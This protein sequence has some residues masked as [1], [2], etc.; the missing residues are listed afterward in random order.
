LFNSGKYQKPVTLLGSFIFILIQAVKIAIVL[1][2]SWNIYNFRLGLVRS[3][4]NEGHEI[5]AVAPYDDYSSKLKEIGC[6]Y[7]KVMMDSRGANPIKDFGLTIELYRIYRRINPD[8]IL[9]FTIKPNIYGTF[10]ARLLGIPAINNVCGLGTVFLNRGIVS[11][12]AK[13][14]YK[15]AFRFPA[16]VLFQNDQDKK[17]FIDE[18]LIQKDI[19]ELIPGSG[20]DLSKFVPAALPKNKD[21]TFL[22]IS[23]LIHDKGIV[24]YIE[25]IKK[26]K[27]QG[28]KARFQILGAIDE[29]HRRGIRAD[30]IDSWIQDGLIEYLGRVP[31]VRNYIKNADCIVLPSYREGTPRTLLEAAGMARPIVTTNV[32]G[33]NNVV[34][35]NYNGFLCDLKDVDDL[36]NK[37]EKMLSLS[38]EERQE[39]GNKG[40]EL[41]ERSYDEYV[42]INKYQE[43]VN[44]VA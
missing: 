28:I 36:A 2:T 41:V 17:L 16:K 18:K 11:F 22:L 7:E 8:I 31:D 33:C 40:R 9:H 34:K 5:I 37:M 29:E 23:R 12:V 26:L 44:N 10:A 20:I 13:M 3:L 38:F 4:I 19:A 30:I 42:V 24:E 35:D 43:L 32:A 14:M 39:F 27:R 21:F 1:N 15:V 6:K 25:A